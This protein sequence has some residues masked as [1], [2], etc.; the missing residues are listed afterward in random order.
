[1]ALQVTIAQRI[2]EIP[3]REGEMVIG[4]ADPSRGVVP[5]VDL[6]ADDAVSR[7]HARITGR[8]GAYFL[9]DLGSTNGTKLNNRWLEP[10]RETR[11]NAG[12]RIELGA[13]TTITLLEAVPGDA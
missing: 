10:N 2:S 1:M 12:D 5:A 11:L 7:R 3:L 9:T 6:S 8:G 4:R 13:L